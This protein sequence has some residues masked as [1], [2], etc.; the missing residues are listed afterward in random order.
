M[1]SIL[2]L[3]IGMYIIFSFS[4]SIL[5][6]SSNHIFLMKK[7]KKCVVVF[8]H[9]ILNSIPAVFPTHKLVYVLLLQSNSIKQLRDC[10]YTC[11]LVLLALYK[12]CSHQIFQGFK[13][14]GF[15]YGSIIMCCSPNKCDYLALCWSP[16]AVYGTWS[17]KIYLLRGCSYWVC[18]PYPPICYSMFYLLFL[19]SWIGLAFFPSLW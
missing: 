17:T 1:G 16:R 18:V 11:Q 5:E 2:L 13:E 14:V 9:D 6:L 8:K 7:G 15:V 4:L 10:S 12:N 19:V 3:A